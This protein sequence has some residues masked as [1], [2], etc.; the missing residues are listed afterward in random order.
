M[1]LLVKFQIL[2]SAFCW[3]DLLWII[4]TVYVIR[5]SERVVLFLGDQRLT[6]RVLLSPC[7]QLPTYFLSQDK[8]D[9]SLVCSRK[10]FQQICTCSI[11]QVQCTDWLY[12]S[13]SRA[14]VIVCKQVL[15]WHF[16]HHVYSFFSGAVTDTSHMIHTGIWE[17][18]ECILFL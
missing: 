6:D 5:W 18:M 7:T 14:D 4:R 8:V 2:D 1:F 3:Y 9:I 11:N 15:S 16:W 17:C 10:W 13:T 12:W